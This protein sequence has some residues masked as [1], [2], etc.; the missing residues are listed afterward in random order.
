MSG[1]NTNASIHLSSDG[2]HCGP[3]IQ[4]FR[5]WYDGAFRS[6]GRQR[7]VG[8]R[9]HEPVPRESVGTL[10]TRGLYERYLHG[11]I[12]AGNSVPRRSAILSFR[13]AAWRNHNHRRDRREVQRHGQLGR[14]PAWQLDGLATCESIGVPWPD[15]ITAEEGVGGPARMDVQIAEKGTFV[16]I[17]RYDHG[18]VGGGSFLGLRVR[19]RLGG[20][21]R[22]AAD[23]GQCQRSS[24]ATCDRSHCWFPTFQSTVSIPRV[25]GFASAAGQDLQDGEEVP[26]HCSSAFTRTQNSL[27]VVGILPVLAL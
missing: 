2:R 25:A 27:E 18:F 14:D 22:R 23:D 4:R 19:R 10:P 17:A 9:G 13:T 16:R 11:G 7:A 6:R 26:I 5:R 1:G 8:G 21:F 15:A 20:G 24:E 3:R 12:W